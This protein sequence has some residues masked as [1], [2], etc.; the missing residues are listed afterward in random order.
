MI[1]YKDYIFLI[2][3]VTIIAKLSGAHFFSLREFTLDEYSANTNPFVNEKDSTRPIMVYHGAERSSGEWNDLIYSRR[4]LAW[5]SK[6]VW[7]LIGV[8]KKDSTRSNMNK[9]WAS[10]P[11]GEYDRVT[12]WARFLCAYTLFWQT[13]QLQSTCLFLSIVS[14]HWDN[15]FFVFEGNIDIGP[16]FFGDIGRNE[17]NVFISKPS[18]MKD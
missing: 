3:R 13:L 16:S 9:F 1:F 11:S 6:L 4:A 8:N 10:K 12:L 15:N 5:D 18:K 7:L 2:L 14:M 17:R